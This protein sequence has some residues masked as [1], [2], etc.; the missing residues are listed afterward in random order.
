[1]PGVDLWALLS[2]AFGLGMLHALDADHVMAVSGLS[3]QSSNH[4]NGVM[5]CMRW[6]LGHGLALLLIGSVVLF[7]GMAIPES[8][9]QYAENLIGLVLI[10]IGLYV[11]LDLYRQ[12]SHVHFHHH[13]GLPDHA[14]WH[15]HSA[16]KKNHS[17]QKHQHAHAPLMVGVLHGVAGSAPLLVLLPMSKLASPWF[18]LAYLMVFGVGV[19]LAMLL[20]GGLLAQMFSSFKKWGNQFIQSLRIGIA[21]LSIAYG[22]KIM[23]TV[24]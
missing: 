24:F 19:F 18:G 9:S 4:K 10:G 17:K 21:C 16:A 15:R 20:F 5:F 22:I 12:R 13:D 14:H 2:L 1:M 6:A 8:L 3:S 11:L 23:M 7:F